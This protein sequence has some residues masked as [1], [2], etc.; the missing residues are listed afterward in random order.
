MHVV[1]VGGADTR[2][3]S[4]EDFAK[5]ATEV[6]EDITFQKGQPLEVSEEVADVLLGDRMLQREFQEA[7]PPQRPKRPKRA[8]R[9]VEEDEEDELDPTAVEQPPVH[10]ENAPHESSAS[11]KAEKASKGKAQRSS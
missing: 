9:E 1:Y 5:Y 2:I 8:P 10:V 4:V 11:G 6:D 3:L 7:D